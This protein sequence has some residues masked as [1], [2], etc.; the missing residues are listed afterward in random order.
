MVLLISFRNIL[1]SIPTPSELAVVEE[2]R[3]WCRKRCSWRP[4]SERLLE[5]AEARIL[6]CELFLETN[7]CA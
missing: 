3:G 2:S 6:Q 1:H 4:T 5:A 7:R